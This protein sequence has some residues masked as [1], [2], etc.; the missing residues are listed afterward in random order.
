MDLWD[1]FV[2]ECES[3]GIDYTTVDFSDW[4]IDYIEDMR[5][6]KADFDYKYAKENPNG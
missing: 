4:S 1:I 3:K 6:D 2:D 5:W